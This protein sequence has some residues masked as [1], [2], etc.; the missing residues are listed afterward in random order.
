MPDG[1]IY[2]KNIVIFVQAGE[3]EGQAGWFLHQHNVLV[4]DLLGFPFGSRS[5]EENAIRY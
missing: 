5:R 1:K 2:C 3:R 4:D